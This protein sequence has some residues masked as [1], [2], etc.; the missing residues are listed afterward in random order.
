MLH[1]KV[2][3]C[4]VETLSLTNRHDRRIMTFVQPSL[5]RESLAHFGGD[6]G[7][8]M[9]VDA[10]L[11]TGLKYLF[12]QFPDFLNAEKQFW[13]LVGVGPVMEKGSFFLINIIKSSWRYFSQDKTQEQH[14]Y[15]YFLKQGF[16]GGLNTF[17]WDMGVH[18]P[19]YCLGMILGQ[20]Y[21]PT[22][23]VGL[24]SAVSFVIGISVVITAQVYLKEMDYKK[25]KSTI[26]SLGFNNENYYDARF[27]VDDFEGA[28]A[29][30]ARIMYNMKQDYNLKDVDDKVHYRDRY[31]STK[32]ETVAGH[33]LHLRE[34]KQVE[35]EGVETPNQ[36][37]FI[38][39]SVQVQPDSPYRMI[40]NQVDKHTAGSKQDQSVDEY[41]QINQAAFLSSITN[42]SEPTEIEYYRTSARAEGGLE[43]S[44]DRIVL[45]NGSYKY[46]LEVKVEKDMDLLKKAASSL[47]EIM[48]DC[49]TSRSRLEL[50]RLETSRNPG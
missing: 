44:I 32:K 26:N 46:Y 1:S 5:F 19:L 6:E 10:G 45:P 49:H 40:I 3:A 48:Q 11:T 18:D 17:L 15:S 38:K 16:D 50:L 33:K 42:G 34:H 47:M 37:V 7:F 9:G 36:V 39:S 31:F 30:F 2:I 8:A 22:I 28:E 23:A 21:F 20:M 13:A 35:G 43:V 27:Y 12:E 14:N 24:I 4:G 25:L 41:K 29:A